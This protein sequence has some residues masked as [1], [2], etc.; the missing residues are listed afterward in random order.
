MLQ[1][2]S[3]DAI[4]SAKVTPSGKRSIAQ[5]AAVLLL[6]RLNSWIQV[7]TSPFVRTD[8]IMRDGDYRVVRRTTSARGE[9]LE[10]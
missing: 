7:P 5:T 8:T 9:S 4:W 1:L 10:I 6:A 3:Y 2:L